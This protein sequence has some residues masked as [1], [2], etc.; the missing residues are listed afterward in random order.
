MFQYCPACG[1]KEIQFAGNKFNCPICGFIYYHNTAAATGCVIQVGDKIALIVRGREPSIGKLDLPGG[2]SD[3]GEGVFE[4]LHREL[5]EELGWAPQI[6]AG[7]SLA[8]VYTLFASFSNK[9]PYK[10]IIYNTCD[11]FFTISAPDLNEKDFQPEAG[12][13][14]ELKLLR[15]QDIKPEDFAFDSIRKAVEAFVEY[16]RKNNEG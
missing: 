1:K 3:P 14:A 7:V 11:M 8:D 10:N 12:E 16:K 5:K 15:P 6:P 9:Y 2:F 4:G 13:V